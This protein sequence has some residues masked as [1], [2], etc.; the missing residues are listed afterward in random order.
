MLTFL[1]IWGL[2]DK[3]N[4]LCT[5]G[6]TQLL[7]LLHTNN[8]TD[9]TRKYTSNQNTSRL[10]THEETQTES[11]TAQHASCSHTETHGESLLENKT[12]S[13]IKDYIMS[14]HGVF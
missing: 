9:T 8:T 13:G 12:L 3:P 11:D 7:T 14:P 2:Y 4:I 1:I 6:Q 10:P 5:P